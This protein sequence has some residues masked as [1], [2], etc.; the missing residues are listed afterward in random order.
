MGKQTFLTADGK[1]VEKGN[2]VFFYSEEDGE[3]ICAPSSKNNLVND[4]GCSVS[5]SNR[6][7]CALARDAFFAIQPSFNNLI[8]NVKQ[9]ATDKDLLKKDNAPKQLGKIMEELGE[10]AGAFLKGRPDE[11]KKEIGDLLVTAILFAAQNDLELDDCL[12]A[13][14]DKIKNRTGKTIN[15]VFIKSDDLSCQQ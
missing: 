15:G 12:A 4:N 6:G 8:N 3:I 10:V 1:E 13:A 14:Y 9:W 11:L 7:A 5:Y 2:D